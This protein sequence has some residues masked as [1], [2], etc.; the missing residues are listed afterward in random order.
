MIGKTRQGNGGEME[1]AY[2]AEVGRARGVLR[3][4]VPD[5][6]VRHAR[7]RPS[8]DVAPW[9]AHYWMVSWD[10]RGCEPYVAETLPHPNVHWVFE[11]GRSTVSGVHT[12]KFSRALEGESQVF[13]VK[14]RPGGFRPFFGAP[15]SELANRVVAPGRI[16]G[17]GVRELEKLVLS[18]CTEDEK[19]QAADAFFRTRAPAPDETVDLAARLVKTVLLESDI[20][21]VD[22]LARR[23]AMGKRSLQRVFKEYVGAS[24]K[25]VIRRYRLHEL[26]ER[27]NS[28]KEIDWVQVALDLGYYDQAHLIKDFRSI[29][30]YSPSQCE[31]AVPRSST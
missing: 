24:P 3:R 31:K 15:V 23:A 29:T 20:R 6:N 22:E 16:F 26:I 9:I 19:V 8:P 7:R 11:N 25:W 2:D 21:T 13:G 17:K 1:E 28:G 27:L 14:F 4:P 12:S 18:T 30:G 10:L 5:G